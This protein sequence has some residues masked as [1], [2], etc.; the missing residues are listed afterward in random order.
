M[1]LYDLNERHEEAILDS[2]EGTKYDASPNKVLMCS[3]Y[4]Y[5]FYSNNLHRFLYA[6]SPKILFNSWYG[7][8][9]CEEMLI[10]HF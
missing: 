9:L 3:T 1:W 8:A 6:G 4:C 10:S 7:E 5:C 2:T